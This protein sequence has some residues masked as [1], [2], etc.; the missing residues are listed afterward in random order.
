MIITSVHV[1]SS[2]AESYEARW[3]LVRGHTLSVYLLS[4]SLAR[5]MLY[6]YG[7]TNASLRAR[8]TQDA[9][10]PSDQALA[11]R[12]RSHPLATRCSS[13]AAQWSFDKWAICAL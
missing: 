8:L 10:A 9:Q 4:H 6:W 3:S 7:N 13:T 12:R 2:P 5:V 11:C 1:T